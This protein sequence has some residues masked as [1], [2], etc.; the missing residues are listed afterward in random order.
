M[1]T[2]SHLPGPAPT[3]Q[4]TSSSIPGCRTPPGPAGPLTVTGPSARGLPRPA[5]EE[6]PSQGPGRPTP[7]NC[8]QPPA[9]PHQAAVATNDSKDPLEGWAHGT[10]GNGKHPAAEWES[11]LNA[12][13]QTLPCS[14]TWAAGDAYKVHTPPWLIPGDP[15][16]RLAAQTQSIERQ[17]DVAHHSPRVCF[18]FWTRGQ[19]PQTVPL[20][21]VSP[22]RVQSPGRLESPGQVPAPAWVGTGPQPQVCQAKALTEAALHCQV[23]L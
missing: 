2:A 3:A 6:S 5:A 19:R 13:Q 22:P 14:L 11:I 20:P 7:E 8:L 1:P 16:G 21:K 18:R 9:S 17:L 10:C 4:E 23:L 15:G 12:R